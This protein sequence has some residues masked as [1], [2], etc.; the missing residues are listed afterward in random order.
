MTAS[1]FDH[2]F[3]SGLLGDDEIAPY[4][5]AEADIRAM[6]SFEAALATA[7]AAHGLIPAEAARRIADTC[8]AFSPDMPS[9]RSATARDG[10][11]VPDLVKQLRADAGEEAAKSLHLGA[12]SQDVIDTSLMIRLK[13]VVFLF[14]GRLSTIAAGLDGLDRQFGR[15][16]LMGHTRMQAAIS[17][18]VA[19]R[20][21]AWRAP[22]ATYRD[23][24][25]EQ[26]FPV[27]FG[28]AAGTL[29][30][31]GSQAAAIRAS[32]AQEL[33][34]T[35]A[36]QWQ[37]GRLPIADI[38]GLFAS[39]SGSLGKMGQDIA[40]LAQAG[41]EIEISG[42]GTSSA[43]AHKQ[44]PVSAEVLISLARFNATVLSGIHQ[45]LVHEQERSGA[46]WTLE[47]LLLPQ[48][49]MATAASL[50]LAKEL[51]GNIRRLGTT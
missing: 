41:D 16:Q 23:R 14:A 7:E 5:S 42:G 48:I 26:G 40:L 20:L 44:N 47:W 31:L 39:I 1:P 38:A 22:L 46:A 2:P 15:N 45:S 10:V 19:D 34:L 18:T 24:L 27:Q 13:A 3:L 21:N 17:I 4:F 25:T 43:M 51:T 30:K 8:A 50:R 32:L 49:T 6:L 33:G 29:D 35:D 37:S 11:V 12:T 36:P 9:L 28:G